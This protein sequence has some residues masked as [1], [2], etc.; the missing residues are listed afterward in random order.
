MEKI[1]FFALPTLA[2][3]TA[4][5]SLAKPTLEL[6]GAIEIEGG[7]ERLD[8]GGETNSSSD[9]ALATAQL[10]FEA[11][12]SE[13]L[14]GTLVLLYEDEED[15]VIKVDEGFIRY[16]RDGW[17]AQCGRQY[18]PFGAFPSH[19]IS[20]PLTLELG[21]TQETAALVGYGDNLFTASVFTFNGD[22]E[23]YNDSGHVNDWGAAVSTTPFY[24]ME[25][26]ASFLSDLSDA[27]SELDLGENGN[28]ENRVAGWSVYATLEAGAFA[29]SAEALGAVEN[30]SDTDYDGDNDGKGD[31]PLA[32]NAELA[33]IASQTLEAALRIEGSQELADQPELQYGL[34]ASWAVEKGLSLSLEYLRGE[35]DKKFS[36]E[37]L[38][39]R[40]LATMQIALE[41]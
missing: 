21:E 25:A 5:Q 30:F 32:W 12:L 31:R 33:W 34:A 3:L 35:F 11:E 8:G 24:G 10:N 29:V 4:S 13:L 1:L 14:S 40:D 36:S 20:D 2:L 22:S 41:F 9:L 27:D 7:Y 26:G 17:F 16:S 39:S 19:F 6:S 28:Y 18:V 23:G 38:D 15:S 37:E